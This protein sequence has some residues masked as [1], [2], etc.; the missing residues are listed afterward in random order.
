MKL[1]SAL[2][3]VILATALPCAFA[4][5]IAESVPLIGGEAGFFSAGFNVTH[6]DAGAFTDTFSFTPS[7]PLS[8]VD[9]SLVTIGFNE[10][11]NIDF[12]SASLNGAAMTLTP[13]GTFET[14]SLSP[15]ALAGDLVLTV[16]GNAGSNASY[17]GT[18]NVSP[19]PEPETYGMLL[20]GMAVLGAIA[21]RRKQ[22]DD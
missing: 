7:V 15:T 4:E 3:S 2:L 9:A 20:G 10:P 22:G 8:L 6:S 21:R 14:G 16:I 13:T 5:D 11:Q 19:V 1:R 12:S 18:L 17:A